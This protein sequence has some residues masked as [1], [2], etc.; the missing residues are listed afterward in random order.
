MIELSLTV[1]EINLVLK[2]LNEL[3]AKESLFLILKLQNEGQRQFDEQ[4]KKPDLQTVI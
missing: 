1:E 4:N 3:P 2:G